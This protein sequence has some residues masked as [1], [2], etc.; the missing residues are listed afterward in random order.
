MNM[1]LIPGSIKTESSQKNKQDHALMLSLKQTPTLQTHTRSTEIMTDALDDGCRAGSLVSRV[2]VYKSTETLC[3]PAT[4]QVNGEPKSKVSQSTKLSAFICQMWVS[5]GQSSVSA[6]LNSVCWC[7]ENLRRDNWEQWNSQRN[8]IRKEIFRKEI[9]FFLFP[10]IFLNNLAL[11]KFPSLITIWNV[12]TCLPDD[13]I[14]PKWCCNI[15]NDLSRVSLTQMI[16]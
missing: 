6:T 13:S 8:N 4:I 16:L 12:I 7:A 1:L 14:C 2:K 3:V 10:L 11:Y 9:F 15:S 5:E